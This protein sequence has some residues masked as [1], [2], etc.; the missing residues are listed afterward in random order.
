MATKSGFANSNTANFGSDED[1]M[2]TESK[3]QSKKETGKTLSEDKKADSSKRSTPVPLDSKESTSKFTE[4]REED[5]KLSTKE[6]PEAKQ[7]PEKKKEENGK[8]PEKTK[9]EKKSEPEKKK[10]PEKKEIEEE[11]GEE[12]EKEEPLVKVEDWAGH[13]KQT[14]LKDLFKV[15]GSFSR[16]GLYA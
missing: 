2:G 15:K 1:S 11:K 6:Q 9:E 3:V 13:A 8:E 5:D 16:G 7:E 12:E 4:R 14:T 10:E